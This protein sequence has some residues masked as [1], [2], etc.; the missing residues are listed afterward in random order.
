[1]ARPMWSG[2]LSF[3]LVNVGVRMYSATED[4]SP[5]FNQFQ[6][7]TSDRIRY[8][9]VNERTGED[10]EYDDIVRGAHL[11]GDEYVLLEQD[12][13]DAVAPGRSRSLEITDF[14][15]GPDIDPIMYG[16]TY[17]LAPRGEESTTAY[18]LLRDALRASDRVGI[19]TFVLRGKEHLAAV[20]PYRNVLALST[21]H[22]A[23]EVRDPDATLGDEPPPRTRSDDKQL[24]VAEQLIE[25]MTERWQPEQ[26]H[27]S[28][29]ERVDE[30]IEAKRAGR[31]V[32][33]EAA[34]PE[35]TKVTDLMSALRDSVRARS[36]S[37]GGTARRGSGSAGGRRRSGAERGSGGGRGSGE[38]RS[39][40]RKTGG[41]AKRTKA[42]AGPKLADA[43]KSELMDLARKLDVS[44]R[45]GMTR[46]EL[47][48]AVRRAS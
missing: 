5:R 38:R 7:G 10:V 1:M 2:S 9:R 37:S 45:S 4:H 6:R 26:Y 16:S 46:D 43:S 21:V 15:P 29:R 41:G 23:D 42:A 3:G 18:A 13:L 34:P 22:F 36:S 14:V 32:V 44:G 28:Y 31:E 40:A 27:D 19:A 25:S 17:Y 47:E 8:R 35:D 11:G 39:G 33:E 20:R 12:E 30:L 24:R 48:R